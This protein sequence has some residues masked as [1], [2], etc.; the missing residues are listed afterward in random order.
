MKDATRGLR[1]EWM[2]GNYLR[3]MP[4]L[5]LEDRTNWYASSR[6]RRVIWSV[7]VI[8]SELEIIFSLLLLLLHRCKSQV[9]LYFHLSS[10][11]FI[12][13]IQLYPRIFFPC[14][15][16]IFSKIAIQVLNLVPDTKAEQ[17]QQVCQ[18]K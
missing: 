5:S 11:F 7:L 12:S 2:E 8:W 15:M 13:F 14:H 10:Q 4:G 18:E 1:E 6:W 3:L 17:I 9:Q 16:T